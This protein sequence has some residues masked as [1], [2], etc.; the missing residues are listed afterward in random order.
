MNDLIVFALKICASHGTKK[1]KPASWAKKTK[2]PCWNQHKN[3]LIFVL[4]ACFTEGNEALFKSNLKTHWLRCYLQVKR[5]NLCVQ[6]SPNH[7]MHGFPWWRHQCFGPCSDQQ[8]TYIFLE[9]PDCIQIDFRKSGQKKN[10]M[11]C[12]FL[13]IKSINTLGGRFEM[14]SKIGF[15]QRRLSLDVLA[16]QHTQQ[17]QTLSHQSWYA[18]LG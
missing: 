4:I 15:L 12:V 16:A 9:Y 2:S 10:D 8:P 18:Y 1:I 14:R 3:Q 7:H 11:K 17:R 5:W 13:L 6:K